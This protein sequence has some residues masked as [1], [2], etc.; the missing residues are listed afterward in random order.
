MTIDKNAL[1]EM[2]DLGW[3]NRQPYGAANVQMKTPSTKEVRAAVGALSNETV[4]AEIAAYK[5]WKL[6]QLQ[7]LINTIDAKKAELL[8]EV[9]SLGE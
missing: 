4:L 2:L 9:A 5:G 8:I 6:S 1:N 3:F 7:A